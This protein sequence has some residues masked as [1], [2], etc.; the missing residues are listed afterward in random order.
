MGYK[1]QKPVGF[2][3][4]TAADCSVISLFRKQKEQLQFKLK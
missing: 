2:K 3:N 4:V 1:L